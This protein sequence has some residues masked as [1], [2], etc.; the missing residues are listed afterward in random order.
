VL[1]ALP[2][3]FFSILS[4]N[5]IGW[6]V[7]IIQILIMQL[8]PLPHPSM[9]WS[10]CQK[11]SHNIPED[12]NHHHCC[13]NFRSHIT[14]DSLHYNCSTMTHT[15]RSLVALPQHTSAHTGV[16]RSD[17]PLLDASHRTVQLLYP[18]RM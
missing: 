18:P 10:T 5:N 8:P 13:K 3:S 7:Q 1:H 11:T 15:L 17:G 12:F 9:H 14:S 2:I 6:A 16:A 4:L